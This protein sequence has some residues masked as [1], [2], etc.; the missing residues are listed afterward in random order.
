MR[1]HVPH[2]P[3]PLDRGDALALGSVLA[4]AAALRLLVL[5][6][7]PLEAS[8]TWV[9]WDLA[10]TIREEGFPGG[11]DPAYPP[12]ASML[13]AGLAP[14]PALLLATGQGLSLAS[15]L[16]TVVP[17]YLLG[18]SLAGRAGGAAAAFFAAVH[19]VLVLYS[20]QFTTEAP[21]LACVSWA[22]WAT[23]RSAEGGSW[24]LAA[25][26]GVLWGAAGWARTEAFAYPLL[27]APL[28]GR[29]GGRRAALA[30]GGAA[31]AALVPF[32]AAVHHRTG[33]WTLRP[34]VAHFVVVDDSSDLNALAEDGSRTAHDRWVED[35]VSL[36]AGEVTRGVLRRAVAAVRGLYRYYREDLGW[37]LGV[38]PAALAGLSLFLVPGRLRLHGV[39]GA[40][41]LATC[42][43]YAFYYYRPRYLVALVPAWAVWAGAGWAAL[44]VRLLE[45]GWARA[46]WVAAGVAVAALAPE[47]KDAT[48]PLYRPE[49]EQPV[50]FRA[51]GR[52]IRAQEG[53][54]R[55]TVVSVERWSALYCEGQFRMW[56]TAPPEEAI[57]YARGH[58]ARW[59]VQGTGGSRW[60]PPC[61][62]EDGQPG[63]RLAHRERAGGREAQVWEVL[64]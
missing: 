27:M 1:P 13:A 53:G 3:H 44:R 4:V 25:A 41:A 31:L 64:P 37:Q 32:L 59:M 15:G 23:G 2:H 33:R 48:Y 49:W 8:D 50:E 40:F 24:R 61:L 12:L 21:Y 43:G 62:L 9:Y 34:G 51:A 45:A 5:G 35:G 28:V 20:T 60:A 22:L 14:G 36:P 54:A 17:V 52:W 46:G 30:L 26:A 55:P 38:L 16:A 11:F 6:A 29:W 57:G 18:R 7:G 10:R 42:L 39:L 58:G 19:A 47:V 56:P 63:V